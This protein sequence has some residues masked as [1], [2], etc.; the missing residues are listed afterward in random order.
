MAINKKHSEQVTQNGLC[1]NYLV[2]AGSFSDWETTVL[3]YKAV[4]MV[5]QYLER[6]GLRPK[7]HLE[8]RNFIR[9]HLRD[10]RVEYNHLYEASIKSRYETDYLSAADKG[11]AYHE[12]VFREAFTP[13][14]QRM[15]RLL[16]APGP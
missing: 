6:Y 16:A 10:I 2:K 3:F 13:F 4:H 12:R 7:D 1:Y 11:K 5:D 9:T 15:T 14:S 8:R